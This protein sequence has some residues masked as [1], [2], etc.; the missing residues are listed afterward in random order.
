MDKLYDLTFYTNHE[1]YEEGFHIGLFTTQEEAES[2]AERYLR[3]V[4]G[5]KDYDCTPRVSAF[6]VIN[7]TDDTKKV[8]RFMGWNTNEDLD[9]VDIIISSC[10]ADQGEAENALSMA[11]ERM[12]RKEWVMNCHTIGQSDWAEGFM[13]TSV[14]EEI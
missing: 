13:R 12:L 4:P 10:F 5:F 1:D 3:E 11:R 9:E 8:Y 6:P 2:V 7:G 14:E